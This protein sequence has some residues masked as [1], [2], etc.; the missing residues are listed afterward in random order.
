MM[1]LVIEREIVVTSLSSS[2]IFT[3]FSQPLVADDGFRLDAIGYAQART[4]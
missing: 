3:A 2:L 4:L 1:G